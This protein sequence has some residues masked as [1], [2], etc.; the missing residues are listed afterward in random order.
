MREGIV[1]PL[2]LSLQLLGS[3]E[4]LVLEHALPYALLAVDPS[5]P[6]TR[7]LLP[8]EVLLKR[9]SSGIE[10]KWA[11]LCQNRGMSKKLDVVLI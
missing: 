5:D 1:T 10:C 2:R 6:P 9:Y 8:R 4:D 11:P 7:Q 3:Q